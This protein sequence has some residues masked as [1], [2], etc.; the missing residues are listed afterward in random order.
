MELAVGLHHHNAWAAPASVSE[1]ELLRM[2]FEVSH[3]FDK[4]V[5]WLMG[6]YYEYVNK[7]AI[8]KDRVVKVAE[9]QA[10]LRGRKVAMEQ[11]RTPLLNLGNL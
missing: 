2:T 8:G 9:L 10:V 3:Y 1:E 11:K 4:E 6:N 7:E 5:T